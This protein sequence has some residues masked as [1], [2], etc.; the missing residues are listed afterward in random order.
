MI[1]HYNYKDG[2]EVASLFIPCDLMTSPDYKFIFYTRI[3]K[4]SSRAAN[5]VL[6]FDCKAL[7]IK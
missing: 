5:K 3:N 6:M 2:F 1:V 7:A 4:L